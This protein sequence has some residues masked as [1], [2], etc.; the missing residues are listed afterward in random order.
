MSAKEFDA[1]TA[2]KIHSIFEYSQQRLG[3]YTYDIVKMLG[4]DRDDKQEYM[5][6][7]TQNCSN[8]IAN[9]AH[10]IC[11]NDLPKIKAMSENILDEYSNTIEDGD[12]IFSNFIKSTNPK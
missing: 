11:E 5:E 10:A 7:L 8:N 12:N 1:A 3:L 2:V 4:E 9:M 6:E